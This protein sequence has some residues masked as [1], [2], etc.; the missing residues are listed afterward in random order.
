MGV[1][2]RLMYPCE[3]I[4]GINEMYINGENYR[5]NQIEKEIQIY[6]YGQIN[7][8]TYYNSFS[9]EKWNKYTNLDTL[10]LNILLKGRCKVTVYN[11]Y[12]TAGDYLCKI[13]YSQEIFYDE[14]T[15]LTIDLCKMIR[16][17]GILAL[18]ILAL[19]ECC[20]FK[21]GYYSTNTEQERVRIGI[22]IC[23]YKREAYIDRYVQAFKNYNKETIGL[24]IAD[25]GGTLDI[26][27]EENLHILK[28][29]NYGGAG[30][31][32]RCMYE[33]K[34]YNENNQNTYT[35]V[36]LMDDD[37]FVDFSIFDR[38][39]AFLSLLKK[40]YQLYFL[41][42]AMC[43]MDYPFLQYEKYSSWTGSGFVQFAPNYDLRD[44]NTI[45]TNEREERLGHCSAGWWCSCF[46]TKM[47]TANNYPFPCFFR[48]DD[49]EFTIRNGSNIITLNGINVWHEPFYKKYSIVSENYY[50]M[51]NILVINS[52]YYPKMNWKNSSKL[53]KQRFIKAIL[54]YDYKGAELIIR[55]IEDYSKGVEFFEKINPEQLNKELLMQNYKSQ[56]LE[57]LVNEYRFDD[58]N[59]DL[60][61]T[62]DKSKWS[63]RIR[64]L[65]LNGYLIP[66][67]FYRDFSFSHVGFGSYTINFYKTKRV[68]S[69]DPFT[70]TGYD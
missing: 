47:I 9:I 16:C 52:L 1:L 51:R 34:K 49:M 15:N 57:K 41:A 63:R 25:N 21:E 22:G 29:K 17:Q 32:A 12:L 7:F 30:G 56:K 20:Y 4:A 23:T 33:I 40:Q 36:V 8:D 60:Y 54:T 67:I 3:K 26:S 27:N 10:F 59:H 2:Y 46:S 35:H 14:Y 6:N 70:K 66:K 53:L 18:E 19:E 31:F 43:S 39:Y 28:N 42:G 45:I 37:L 55:A 61:F 5:I 65:T 64:L 44:C 48:G 68:I 50:L 62:R 38:M 69:F 24:F 11:K 13:V 58:I